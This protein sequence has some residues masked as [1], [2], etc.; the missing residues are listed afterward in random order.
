MIAEN[1]KTLNTEDKASVFTEHYH[2]VL[3]WA[4]KKMG[5][6]QDAEDAAS[7]V[8]LRLL[9]SRVDNRNIMGWLNTVLDR[10]ILDIN[11]KKNKE[12]RIRRDCDRTL[13]EED[14]SEPWE[15]KNTKNTLEKMSEHEELE[16]VF[17]TIYCLHPQ[18]QIALLLMI[19]GETYKEIAKIQGISEAALKSRITRARSALSKRLEYIAK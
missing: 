11:R 19:K 2:H 10:R 1:Y 16:R 12:Y 9:E 4:F 15:D 5:N 7:Y 14:F 17:D 3:G 18:H 13:A 6:L 8:F